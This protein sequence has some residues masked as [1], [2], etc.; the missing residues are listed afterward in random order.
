MQTMLAQDHALSGVWAKIER[1]RKHIIDFYNAKKAF[2]ESRPFTF[3]HQEDPDTG[4][5]IVSIA[6]IRPVPS[7]LSLIIGDAIHNLRSALD[8]LACQLVKLS[9]NDH[10]CAYTYFPVSES[11][12]K[13]RDE[14]KKDKMQLMGKRVI[15]ILERLQ[16]Y[17]GGERNVLWV[18]H[19]LDIQDK[20]RLLI[21]A[22]T[23]IDSWHG[24]TVFIPSSP[25][26]GN[27]S[28]FDYE[29]AVPTDNL[30]IPKIGDKIGGIDPSYFFGSMEGELQVNFK[31][32]G[33]IAFNEPGIIQHK[34]AFNTLRNFDD[35]VEDTVKQFEPFF[36]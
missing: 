19:R 10:D 22:P 20:H 33:D 2:L 24:K 11:S 25:D 12:R 36:S 27:N 13:F 31:I 8:L 29:T 16:P 18:L 26:L 35:V 21:V 34:S 14:L 28:S 4:H 30:F 5:V 15:S 3:T 32:T 9:V 6:D 1:G 17:R 7:E 23:S